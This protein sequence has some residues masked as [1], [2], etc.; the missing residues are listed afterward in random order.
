[1]RWFPDKKG[2]ASGLPV[3]GFG[4]GALIFTPIAQ[5]L[6]SKFAKAPTYV[7]SADQFAVKLVDGKMFTEVCI[8]Q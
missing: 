4:S 2:I 1:M 3:A 5:M 8:I 7:G 6:M